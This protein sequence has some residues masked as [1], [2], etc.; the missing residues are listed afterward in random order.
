MLLL[1]ALVLGGC[2]GRS[3]VP[4]NAGVV[5]ALM[6]PP[7]AE[8]AVTYRI[9]AGDELHVRF[10]YQPEMNEELPVRPDGRITLATTGEILV[11]GMTPAELEELIAEKSSA[12]LRDPEVHVILTKVAEQRV[13]VGGEVGAG[14]MVLQPGMT[15]WKRS[16]NRGVPQHGK[17]PERALAEPA[18]RGEFSAAR[19]NLKQVVEEGVPER[20]RLA[21]GAVLNVP[22]S[23]IGDA[24]EVVDL[25]VRGLIRAAV[26]VGYSLSQ[27]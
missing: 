1:P 9:Q 12:R 6:Q 26:G 10:T 7:P 22:P 17:A 23:W 25:Y 15:R 11:A 16:A 8:A 21:A 19:L 20:V 13:Y 2:A 24:N 4:P 5:G 3:A 14:P 27:Q 18:P